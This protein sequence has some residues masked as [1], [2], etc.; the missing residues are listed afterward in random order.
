MSFRAGKGAGAG[1]AARAAVSGR[2]DVTCLF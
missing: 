1:R 2:V